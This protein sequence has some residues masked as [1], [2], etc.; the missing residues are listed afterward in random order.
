MSVPTTRK[1]GLLDE[2]IFI[3]PK[4]LLNP[5]STLLSKEATSIRC[6]V[7]ARPS[8]LGEECYEIV[9]FAP[10][11]SFNTVIACSMVEIR[12]WS[13][14]VGQKLCQIW[15][16]L[17][18]RGSS[19]ISFQCQLKVIPLYSALLVEESR[20]QNLSNLIG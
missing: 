17:W 14:L 16:V 10:I 8:L 1:P 6:L 15:R 11:R 9:S 2:Q 13:F 7:C 20:V 3:A 18:D 12:K 19:N 4:W 5:L